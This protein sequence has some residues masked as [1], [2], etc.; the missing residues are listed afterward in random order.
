MKIKLV[1]VLLVTVSSMNLIANEPVE[2]PSN[3]EVL[4]ES[5]NYWI[6]AMSKS[7]MEDAPMFQMNRDAFSEATARLLDSCTESDLEFLVAR[8]HHV[9]VERIRIRPS[10]Q[11]QTALEVYRHELAQAGVPENLL[12]SKFW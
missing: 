9:P 7:D 3:H 1:L 5:F 4:L 8:F 11:L 2:L 12:P 6:D 10:E